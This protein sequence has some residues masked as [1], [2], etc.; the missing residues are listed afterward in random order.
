VVCGSTSQPAKIGVLWPALVEEWGLSEREAVLVDRRE[1]EHC[2]DCGTSLRSAAFAVSILRYLG[3]P[4]TFDA[5]TSSE[6]QL[7]VLEITALDN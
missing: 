4:G 6:T 2:P 7:R 5:W 3:W 1:G